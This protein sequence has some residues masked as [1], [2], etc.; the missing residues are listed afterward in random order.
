MAL[1]LIIYTL[2]K[3]NLHRFLLFTYDFCLHSHIVFMLIKMLKKLHVLKFRIK[4]LEVFP[5]L[6]AYIF[7]NVKKNALPTN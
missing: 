7:Q 6:K 5:K 4:T 2:Y 3:T 1:K